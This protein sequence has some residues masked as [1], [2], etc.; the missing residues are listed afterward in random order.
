MPSPLPEPH[1]LNPEYRM[2]TLLRDSLVRERSLIADALDKTAA[3]M[4]GGQVWI[5]STAQ[6]FAQEVNVRQ[7]R[8]KDR[9]NELIADVSNQL[10]NTPER[11]PA[12]V[13]RASVNKNDW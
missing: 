12:S 13:A 1:V 9:M 4:T 10:R 6:A 5:G 7:R 2:L 11:V 3:D 8:L